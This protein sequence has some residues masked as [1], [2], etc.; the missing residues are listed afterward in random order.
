MPDPSSSA[1]LPARVPVLI[2]G[3]HGPLRLTRCFGKTSCVWFSA[4]HPGAKL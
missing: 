3:A 1:S 2:A 4:T